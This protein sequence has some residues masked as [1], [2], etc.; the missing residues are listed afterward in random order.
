MQLDIIDYL[1][2]V[3]NPVFVSM[4]DWYDSGYRSTG[5]AISD[6]E[7]D[8][9]ISRICEG[10][11]Y[12]CLGNH[13]FL[14]RDAN[15]E[16]YIIQPNERYQ[17]K[18]PTQ[19]K[20]PIFKVVDDI[21]VGPVQVSLF[22]FDKLNKTYWS[23]RRPGTTFRVGVYHDDCTLPS[24][25][26]QE[27]GYYGNTENMYLN[28]VYADIDLALHGH[29][30]VPC[31]NRVITLNQ[32]GRKVPLYIPGS[33]AITQNKEVEKH[34]ETLCPVVIVDSDTGEAKFET[35][36]IST[37]MELLQFYNVSEKKLADNKLD[38]L[39]SGDE[40]KLFM[41][42]VVSLKDFLHT[43][44]YNDREV[45]IIMGVKAGKTDVLTLMNL[46][47]GELDNGKS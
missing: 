8:R 32:T 3:E 24:D 47:K 27:A 12:I 38:I 26:R 45:E 14:E 17:P 11:A 42:N 7:L 31:G 15:P 20:Q 1:K 43:E 9:E 21:Q 4:G 40:K 22:H 25:I 28:N 6:V 29:I 37:H 18:T 41:P 30:H 2:S 46:I 10:D 44:G 16:M 23:K 36:K 33:L 19:M 39:G 34:K 35:V 13:F 5:K